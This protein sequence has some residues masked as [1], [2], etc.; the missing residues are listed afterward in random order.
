MGV[1]HGTTSLEQALERGHAGQGAAR[2][3]GEQDRNQPYRQ[4]GA[5]GS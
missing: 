1:G 4:H 5:Q 3:E 2:G